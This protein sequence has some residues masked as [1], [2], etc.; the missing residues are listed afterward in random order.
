MKIQD[1]MSTAVTSCRPGDN[2]SQAAQAMWDG[3]LGCL[4]VVDESTKVIGMITD[5]DLCM[6]TH[7]R[8]TPMWSVPVA[9]VMAKV[10]YAVHASEKLRAAA[11][12]MAHHQL[13]RLP[14][15]DAEGTLV[16][17]ITL[18]TL[19]QAAASKKK[20]S[21]LSA[22]DVFG[23]LEAITRPRTEAVIERIEVEVTRADVAPQVNNVLQPAPR[24][25]KKTSAPAA[26]KD[27]PARKDKKTR[28]AK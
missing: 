16:G 2:L 8:G 6:A 7:M 4:P 23:I 20:K 11:K 17:M 21:S 10:V 25:A 1:L 5:R 9:E 13:R 15:V 3:D 14:V 18:S 28:V 12:L 24:K 19:T 26:A 22:K 27:K